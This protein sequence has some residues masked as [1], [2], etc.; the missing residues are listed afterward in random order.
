MVG[1][2]VDDAGISKHQP[3]G[4]PL[5][6]IQGV[7]I[8]FVI[9]IAAGEPAIIVIESVAADT[10]SIPGQGSTVPSISVLCLFL[11]DKV[12]GQPAIE[13]QVQCHIVLAGVAAITV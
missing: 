7:D 13:V 6:A 9:G 2:I 3:F 8:T 12:V 10:H 1:G 11:C 4:T 5:R